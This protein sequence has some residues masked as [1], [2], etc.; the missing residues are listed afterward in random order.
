[1]NREGERVCV[2]VYG[3]PVNQTD[4]YVEHLAAIPDQTRT[5][6]DF[7]N[8]RQ[9]AVGNLEWWKRDESRRETESDGGDVSR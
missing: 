4:Q 8:S 6:Q 9:S 2:C 3:A 5:K 7:R 1:M